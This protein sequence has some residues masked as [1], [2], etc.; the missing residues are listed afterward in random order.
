MIRISRGLPAE[1]LVVVYIAL[2][3][4]NTLVMT[5]VPRRLLVFVGILLLVYEALAERSMKYEQYFLYLLGAWIMLALTLNG[6]IF[7]EWV[8]ECV[9]L[10]GNLGVAL[11]LC[12]GHVR[13]Q[14]TGVLFYL[15][16]A[17]FGYRLL[18][19]S[20]P[21]AIHQIMVT[22]SAN[23]ISGYL[24]ILCCLHYAVTLAGG[25]R[26]RLLPAVVCLLVSALTLG[27][28]GISAALFLIGGVALYDLAREH[29][30]WLLAVKLLVYAAV[31]VLAVVVVLP[32]L[33]MISFVFERFSEFGFGSEARSHI[34]QD[35]G[36]T[37]E[38]AA[39]LTGHGR[40]EIFGGFTNVHNSY[41]L[42]HKSMGLMAIPLYLLSAFALV[43]ALR[44]DRMVF[45]LLAV[46]LFRAF[47]DEL[48][49]PFRLLDFIFMYLVCTSLVTLAQGQQAYRLPRPTE[50]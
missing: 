24:L 21:G 14:T 16:A 42:W 49:L 48:L 5:S 13:R 3:V 34:W 4:T 35:Y 8:Q 39:T 11:A 41:I 43:R 18:T 19:V 2:A 31:M 28:S 45:L 50:A 20:S 15:T 12:R 46:L 33:D 25:A 44:H 29:R 9:Y 38:G 22:G 36:K 27:R 47:F 30:R 40:H 10:P 1:L 17:Y 7:G 23:G 32:R 26:I 37:L 6:V